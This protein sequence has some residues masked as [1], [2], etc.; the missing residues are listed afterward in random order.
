MERTS[1]SGKGQVRGQPSCPM[2]AGRTEGGRVRGGRRSG[3]WEQW[4]GKTVVPQGLDKMATRR[5][6]SHGAV[7]KAPFELGTRYVAW[8][9]LLQESFSPL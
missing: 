1:Q 5:A 8:T 7:C 3:G 4:S 6:P 9:W 2:G